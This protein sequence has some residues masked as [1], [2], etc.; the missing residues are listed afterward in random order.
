M[1][2]LPEVDFIVMGEG[3]ETFHHLLTE[4]WQETRKFHYVFGLAYRKERGSRFVNRRAAEAGS[5]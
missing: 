1:E 4:I 3:E 5:G 2:R